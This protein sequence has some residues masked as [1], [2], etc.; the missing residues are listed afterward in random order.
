MKT[1]LKKFVSCIILAGMA[2]SLF[3]V[4]TAGATA[5]AETTAASNVRYVNASN[6]NLRKSPSLK[7]KVLQV[8]SKNTKVTFIKS[9]KSWSKVKTTKGKTGYIKSSYLSKT[10]KVNRGTVDRRN[11]DPDDVI[12]TAKNYLGTPYKYGGDSPSG[13][14]C[15]GFVKYVFAQY[16]I[17]LPHS[18]S[19]MGDKG[20]SVKKD[21]LAKCDIVL[22][23]SGSSINHVGIYIGGGEMIHASSSKGVMISS[24]NDSYWGPRYKKARKII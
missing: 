11:I 14:D 16:G 20:K 10:Q 7:S 3:A 8:L 17:S 9:Q 4:V 6:V 23:G 21:D 15:S 18:A 24:I 2:Y 5:D 13:F 19:Q 1:Y 22:F 12:K